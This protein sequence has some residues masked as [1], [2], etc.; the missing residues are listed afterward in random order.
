MV[1]LRTLSRFHQR[2][3][4]ITLVSLLGLFFAALTLC[5]QQS[6]AANQ[7]FVDA[8]WAGTSDGILK[9]ADANGTILFNVANVRNVRTVAIDTR[10]GVLW[11]AD[12]KTL[13]AY[14]FAGAL[15]RTIPV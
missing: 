2:A 14:N 9:I 1:R 13:R 10:R 6:S 3:A 5:A 7:L 4:F 11:A 8:L 12:G 15:Q